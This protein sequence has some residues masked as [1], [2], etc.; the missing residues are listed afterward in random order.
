M[1]SEHGV[2]AVMCRES[3]FP[4][5]FPISAAVSPFVSDFELRISDFLT[6]RHKVLRP[7]RP[8]L[9]GGT[10]VNEI[11]AAEPAA[12]LFF[13]CPRASVARGQGKKR[14]RRTDSLGLSASI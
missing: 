2:Q 1:K 14:G 13:P 7:P 5:V 6:F 11:E 9:G 10:W 4:F 3:R 12:P 8:R